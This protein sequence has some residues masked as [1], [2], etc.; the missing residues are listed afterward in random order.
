VLHIQLMMIMIMLK[1]SLVLFSFCYYYKIKTSFIKF[2]VMLSFRRGYNG[3][4]FMMLK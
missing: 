3:R 2:W 4:V 1:L